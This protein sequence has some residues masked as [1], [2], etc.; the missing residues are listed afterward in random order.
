M[1]AQGK[2]RYYILYSQIADQQKLRNRLEIKLVD[3]GSEV[4]I[5][6]MEYYKRGEKAVKIK[7]IFPNYMFIYTD[8]NQISKMCVFIS[9]F[10]YTFL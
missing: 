4:F 3:T 8:I 10:F 1:S 6:Y 7:P 2:K 9:I 5:P